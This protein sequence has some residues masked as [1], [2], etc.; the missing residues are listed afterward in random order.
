MHMEGLTEMKW[1]P[2]AGIR[3]EGLY[4]FNT[5]QYICEQITKERGFN[6]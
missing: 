6:F 2:E 4:H 5:G 3:P 1:K